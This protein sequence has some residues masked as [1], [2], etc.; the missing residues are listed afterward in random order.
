MPDSNELLAYQVEELTSSVKALTAALAK[1][2]EDNQKRFTALEV[3][4]AKVQITS[5]LWGAIGAIVV[6]ESLRRLL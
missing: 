3:A 5:S 1:T 2:N 6:S 4:L